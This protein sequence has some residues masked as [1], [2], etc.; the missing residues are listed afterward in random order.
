MKALIVTVAG[1][2]TRFNQDTDKN[3]LKCLYYIGSPKNSLL[4]CI[5]DKSRDIDYFIIVGGYLFEEL[6]AFVEREL[7]EFKD[8]IILVYNPHY[9][10]YGSGY[11]LV[12]GVEA[13]PTPTDEVLF[14]EGDL[15]FD[16]D[17][18]SKIKGSDKDVITVNRELISSNKSVV[19]YTDEMGKIHY[20]YDVNHRVLFI[21]E[22]FTGIYNSAQI[23]KFKSIINLKEV[24]DSLS[25]TQLRGTNLEI[26]QKYYENIPVAKLD[27]IPV[28]IWF[29]CNTVSDYKKVYFLLTL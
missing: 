21:T 9:K 28:E 4:Y 12:K 17:S 3:T 27:I 25:E 24:I 13:L 15:Y 22:P 5:L 11:S 10:D 8:K 1:T 29:N 20:L 16:E 18:F 7:I 19:I 2:A 6:T 23:W 26:I 14:V